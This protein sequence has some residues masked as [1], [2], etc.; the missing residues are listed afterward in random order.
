[1]RLTFPCTFLFQVLIDIWYLWAQRLFE[2]APVT[3]DWYTRHDSCSCRL[4]VVVFLTSTPLNVLHSPA[5]GALDRH[6]IPASFDD[7]EWSVSPWETVTLTD[8]RASA[9]LRR[10]YAAPA[11]VGH[12]REGCWGMVLRWNPVLYSNGMCL[13]L[14]YALCPFCPLELHVLL[15]ELSIQ[16]SCRDVHVPSSRHGF[17]CAISTPGCPLRVTPHALPPSLLG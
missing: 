17:G 4:C 12:L 10:V 3:G 14:L 6:S 13:N 2:G 9:S 8:T 15:S 16:V 11:G 7:E 5:A 1:M